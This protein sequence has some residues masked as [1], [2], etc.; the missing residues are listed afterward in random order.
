[1]LLRPAEIKPY[2]FELRQELFFISERRSVDS[3]IAEIDLMFCPYFED[4]CWA[5][6]LNFVRF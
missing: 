3:Q 6:Q 2:S 1:M 4:D 5:V